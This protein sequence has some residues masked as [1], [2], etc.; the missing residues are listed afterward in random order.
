MIHKCLI[1]NKE[2]ESYFE[3]KEKKEKKKKKDIRSESFSAFSWSC[4]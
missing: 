2:E 4:R 1:D 3:K